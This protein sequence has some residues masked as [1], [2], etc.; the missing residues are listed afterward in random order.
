M[1]R[2]P[3]K[4]AAL[5]LATG[6]ALSACGGDADDSA[7]GEPLSEELAF[8]QSVWEANCQVC[9]G[10]GLAGA[11][12]AGDAEAW[13]PRLAK[14]EDTL[15]SHAINGFSGPGGHQMPARGGNDDLSDE[16]VAAAVAYMISR[17]Q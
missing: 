11:P 5:V 12:P 14:G 10:P 9:H 13:A 2:M 6:V 4:T 3:W 16:E 15:V 8:G 1:T 7:T 17:S